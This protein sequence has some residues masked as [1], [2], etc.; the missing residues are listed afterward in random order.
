MHRHPR[1]QSAFS[2]QPPDVRFK[3]DQSAE[4]QHTSKPNHLSKLDL[5]AARSP[6]TA[7]EAVLELIGPTRLGIVIFSPITRDHPI[8]AITRLLTLAS[9]SKA[10]SGPIELRPRRGDLLSADGCACL[11]FC[12]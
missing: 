10:A 6:L 4:P 5:T 3:R 2:N 9:L 11:I 12:G 8:T 7:H 1:K